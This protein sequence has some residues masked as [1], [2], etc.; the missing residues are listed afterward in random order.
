MQNSGAASLHMTAKSF[1]SL[2][3]STSPV[4]VIQTLSVSWWLW[5]KKK[6]LQLGQGWTKGHYVNM[7]QKRRAL[8]EMW[9]GAEKG[10]DCQKNE[11]GERDR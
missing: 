1:G 3:K 4:L 9:G 11:W 8:W 10:G 6:R 7:W 5:S 2:L